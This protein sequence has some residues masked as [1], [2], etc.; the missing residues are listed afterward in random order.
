VTAPL[1]GP[2][3]VVKVGGLAGAGTWRAVRAMVGIKRSLLLGGLRGSTQQ[4]IQTLLALVFSL[5]LGVFGLA[6]FATLG[7][8][9][10]AGD[11]IIVVLLPVLVLG[12]GLLAAAAGVETTIDVRNLATEPL[13]AHEFGTATLAAALLG[14][15]ALMAGISGVGL[16]LGWGRPTLLTVLVVALV[17]VAWW[18]TLLLVSRTAANALGVLA[19]GRF[20]QVAQTLAAL[21]SLAVWFTAQFAANSLSKWDRSS[22]AD[23]ARKFEWTPPGQLGRALGLA[24]TRPSAALVHLLLGVA[25]LPLLWVVHT[26]T[27]HRLSISPSRPGADTRT[28]RTGEDGVRA[29]ALRLLPAGAAFA[30]TART[31]R[32]KVRTPREAVNSVV[33]FVVGVGALVLGPVL[34]G[35]PDGRIVLAAGLLHFAVLFEGNNTFGFDGPALWMEVMAGADG[36]A[37]ARGKAATSVVT[38]AVPALA[39]V[40]SLA[41]VS[42]GWRWV[43]AGLLLAL[44][45]MLL[46]AGASVASAAAAPF[47]VP[48][49]PNPFAA[50]DT[51]QG[52]LAGGILAV[53]MVALAVV[54]VPVALAVWWASLRS[55]ELTALVALVAPLAGLGVLFGGIALASKI[56]TGHEHELVQKVTP[57]R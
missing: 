16:G 25:W 47:S 7:R 32:T 37:L 30:I 43:P 33:A 50:G 22:W 17:V 19:I 34:A 40:V 6:V 36:R 20:R 45:S 41:A 14:P 28:I 9:F 5:A 52:C 56:L 49:S 23:L 54:S 2:A 39:L 1:P 53:D 8:A 57:A 35:N 26:V 27:T 13:T 15:P 10:V 18:A 29:G 12:I 48:D 51:G 24:A 31:M 55:P 3:P 21:A 44:G 4:R 46:A 38:M 11:E 42:G